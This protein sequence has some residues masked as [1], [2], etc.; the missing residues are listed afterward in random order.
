MS[1]DVAQIAL[2][3]AAGLAFAAAV[4]VLVRVG[5][6]DRE[7]SA[8]LQ[9]A[10]DTAE[11][12][13]REML[14]D[15]GEALGRVGERF[16]A[17]NNELSDRL[18]EVLERQ[19]GA[20]R[21]TLDRQLTGLREA[22]D[23]Q[24]ADTRTGLM[25]LQSATNTELGQQREVLVA[26]IAQHRS[27]TV[28]ALT[29][30]R[31]TVEA[32][33][34]ELRQGLTE[35]LGTQREAITTSLVQ[36]RDTV[37][38]LLGEQRTQLLTSLGEQRT[39][40]GAGLGQQ[41]EAIVAQL[42]QMRADILEQSL[43]ALGEQGRAQIEALNHALAAASQRLTESVTLL[44]TTTHERLESIQGKVDARLEA[45]FAKTN[46]TFASVMA[47][48]ATIDEAQKKIDGLTTNVVS[49]QELLGDKR[50]RGAFGEVQ[51]ENL[52]RNILPATHYEFQFALRPNVRVDCILR[53]P[54]P[55]GIVA[56]DS[57]FPLENWHRGF[58]RTL[59]DPERAAAQ[60]QFGADVRKHVDDIAS[61]YIV[62]GETA[63]GAVMFVPA[64]AVF[65]EIHAYHA[66]VVE[67]AMRRHVWIVSPTTMMAVLNTARAVIKDVET[68]K[69]VHLIKDELAKLGKD[70]GRF[71][72]RMR[73]LATH[74]K[75]AHDDAEQ[76]R[77][78][79][80]KIVKRFNQIERVE[81][82][83]PG[84][85]AQLAEAPDEAE[86]FDTVADALPT[87]GAL[88]PA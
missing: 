25:T 36:Q 10:T 33:L 46:E 12:R 37:L 40:V 62:A 66:D 43:K 82:D 54:E 72:E 7:Q 48:L 16:G 41:R 3:V 51:L 56:V 64:E 70:F 80:D 88:P 79:S 31:E 38:A 52:V 2:F 73:K 44:N 75:Q 69:Q 50:S 55:T 22:T 53:L 67:H 21:D 77:T 78:S 87:G 24:L 18:R 57:K 15:M 8:A 86:L 71:D 13:H 29:A 76:V 65:A 6:L 11:A 63:D 1:P 81:L 45:G 20:T 83:A 39:E 58:D 60:K 59:S 19:L 42:A 30:Q 85:A 84:A 74:I 35:S 27:N 14:K 49:L 23:R 61:K 9:R 34:G 47:R 26:Q 32:R 68:R 4:L 17:A 28:D 5:R